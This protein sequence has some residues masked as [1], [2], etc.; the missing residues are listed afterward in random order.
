MVSITADSFIFPAEGD[1]ALAID[2]KLTVRDKSSD[3]VFMAMFAAYY[4]FDIKFHKKRCLT[5]EFFE[6]YVLKKEAKAQK[7]VHS[8]VKNLR[9][10]I[11][12]V[13][14]TQLNM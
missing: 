5:L 14:M 9:D 2:C 11:A 1:Y 4:V 3:N 13:Y 7:K 10:A 12:E 8:K 6:R